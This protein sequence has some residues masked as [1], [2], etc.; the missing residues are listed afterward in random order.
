[1]PP[2]SAVPLRPEY[3]RAVGGRRLQDAEPPI[4]EAWICYAGSVVSAGAQAGATLGELAAQFGPELTGHRSAGD[5]ARGPFSSSCWTP[6]TGS[7]CRC[8]P[9]TPRLAGWRATAPAAKRRPGTLDAAPGARIIAGLRPG[10]GRA[11]LRRAV[12]GGGLLHLLCERAVAQ[13]DTLLIPAGTVHAPGPGLLLYELQ[14]MS[15]ITYR[16]WDWTGPQ[17]SSGRF[18]SNSP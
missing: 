16:L 8:T 11:A 2:L 17:R 4:G 13:G 1:M 7:P 14:Q 5:G 9:T 6:P 12:A 3:R 18:T 15:D 10:S